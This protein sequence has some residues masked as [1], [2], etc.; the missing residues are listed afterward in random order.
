MFEF[1]TEVTMTPDPNNTAEIAETDIVFECP[2]C[3]KSLAI[4]YRGAGLTVPCTDC[5]KAVDIP[6]P[7]DMEPAAL[8]ATDED[9]R[10]RVIN[11]REALA[12]SQSEIRT[13]EKRLESLVSDKEK[14]TIS[15]GKDTQKL[16][17]IS[18]EVQ[19]ISKSIEQITDALKLIGD[20]LGFRR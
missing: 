13:L 4:D 15:R 6:I 11:L 3:R 2:Y 16:K 20:E 14:A 17:T 9:P 19:V 1:E 10:A 12:S 18:R 5:G 8:D 7:S